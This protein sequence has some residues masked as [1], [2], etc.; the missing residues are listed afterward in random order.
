[1][2]PLRFVP[3]DVLIE[4]Y[5]QDRWFNVFAVWDGR[6][7]QLRGFYVNLSTPARVR[8]VNGRIDLSYTDL[9]LDVVITPG[10]AV[11]LDAEDWNA[12][13]SVL[14][15]AARRAAGAELEEVRR[16]LLQATPEA[17]WRYLSDHI[18]ACAEGAGCR[19]LV[20]TAGRWGQPLVVREQV[21][22]WE[23]H[24]V[25]HWLDLHRRGERVAE[26]IYVLRLPGGRT[27]LHTKAFYPEGVFRLPGGGIAGGETPWDAAVREALEETGLH[28][29]PAALLGYADIEIVAGDGARVPMPNYVFLLAPLDPWA[30]PAPAADEGITAFRAVP[31]RDLAGSAEV[32]LGL[33]G[34]WGQWG[35]YRA[36][37]HRL[38]YEA[39]R[40]RYAWS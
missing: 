37:G 34:Q 28:T 16:R 1:M 39:I 18:Q 15:D 13:A 4:R 2:G 19:F 23:P 22:F 9:G 24:R 5:D 21:Q 27:L 8:E 7:G 26:A 38:A 29:R 33:E 25:E 30:E 17:A 36:I 20:E 6:T 11:E 12:A 40:A 14:D 10:Q 32:L 35:R 3:G 31:W